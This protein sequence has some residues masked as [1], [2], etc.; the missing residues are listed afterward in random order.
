RPRSGNRVRLAAHALD[1]PD[2]PAQLAHGLLPQIGVGGIVDVGL[3]HGV[4]PRSLPPPSS[5]PWASLATG[6][7][8][9][10]SITSGPARRTSLTSVVGCGTGRSRPMRQNRRQPIESLTSCTGSR[11]PAGSGALGIA[12]PARRSP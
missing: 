10:S 6:A 2:Q 12:A 3:H 11:S 9:S 7:A 5:L 1:P 8:F 4:S